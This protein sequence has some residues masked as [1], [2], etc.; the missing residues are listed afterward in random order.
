MLHKSIITKD[1]TIWKYYIVNYIYIYIYIVIIFEK[2]G[3]LI[4]LQICKQY[5]CWQKWKNYKNLLIRYKISKSNFPLL[6]SL[7]LYISE[8]I[9]RA[10]YIIGCI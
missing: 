7:L 5:D 1:K 10:L 9:L 4:I 6:R 2:N 3:L 8:K